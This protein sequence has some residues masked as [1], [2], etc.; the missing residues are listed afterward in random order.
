MYSHFAFPF[1]RSDRV[2]DAVLRR[3]PQAQVNVIGPRIPLQQLD[4]LLL[5]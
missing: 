4:S 3:D 1:Q 5:A 2:G